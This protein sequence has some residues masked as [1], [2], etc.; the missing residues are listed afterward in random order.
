[1]V[2]IEIR[3]LLK[4]FVGNG[5]NDSQIILRG[6]VYIARGP[7]SLVVACQKYQSCQEIL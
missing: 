6:S 1:L 3:R 4:W 7:G 2:T 5:V